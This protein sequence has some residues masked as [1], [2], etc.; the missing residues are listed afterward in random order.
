MEKL[1]PEFVS[2]SIADLAIKDPYK[3]LAKTAL[4]QS[5]KYFGLSDAEGQRGCDCLFAA[6][7]TSE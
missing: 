4:D 2:R 3:A 1:N 6:Q 5:K 7:L